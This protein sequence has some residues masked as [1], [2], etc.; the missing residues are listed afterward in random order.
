MNPIVLMCDLDSIVVDLMNPWYAEHNRRRGDD[1]TVDKTTVWDV[2]TIA[3][4]GKQIFDVISEPGFFANLPWL[5]GAKEAIEAIRD[6]KQ[7]D[8]VSPKFDLFFGTAAETGVAHA[9]KHTWVRREMP[10]LPKRR[11]MF[12]HEKGR[13]HCD[14]FIDD[15][16]HNIRAMRARQPLCEILTIGYPY[17][18]AERNL[19]DLY[20]ESH[21]DTAAA[22]GQIVRY[23]GVVQ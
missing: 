10:W 15:G 21:K 2:D 8:G 9:D 23:L 6:A 18:A 1:L 20:A 5:P 16:P 4:G 11:L 14:V 3:K 7:A 17:N 13:F 19:V 12:L 22:W